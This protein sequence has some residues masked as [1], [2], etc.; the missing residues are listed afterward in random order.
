M[1][2]VQAVAT[3]RSCHLEAGV[4]DFNVQVAPMSA[5]GPGQLGHSPKRRLKA[6]RPRVVIP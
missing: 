6:R 4:T 2:S 1:T 3:V 5:A